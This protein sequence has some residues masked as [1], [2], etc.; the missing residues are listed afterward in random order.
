MDRIESLDSPQFSGRS[1][2]K[3]AKASKLPRVSPFSSLVEEAG[4]QEGYLF[5]L[6]NRPEGR[7]TLEAILDEVHER[8]ERLVQS[9]TLEHI[10]EYRQ[11]VRGFLDFVVRNLLALE[12][13]TSGSNVQKRKRFT[14]I[15]VIDQRLEQLVTAVL[16]NQGK[17]LNILERVNEIRGLLVNLIT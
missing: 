6:E 14:Q 7:R 11:A 13:K 9:P 12:E 16:Q 1:R 8:G 17:Q 2:R 10:K 15:R 3:K 5:D 4:E